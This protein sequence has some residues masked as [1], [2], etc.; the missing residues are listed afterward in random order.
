ME[1]IQIGVDVGGTFTDVVVQELNT[2]RMVLAKSFSTPDDPMRGIDDAIQRAL[3]E[4][5]GDQRD[6][7][8]VRHG[9]TIATNAA[10]ERRGAKTAL[11]T[12]KGF[13]DVLYVGRQTRPSL[14]NLRMRHPDPLVP[15]HLTF[16]V[17]ERLAWN[18]VIERAVDRSEVEAIAERLKVEGIETIAI[19][20]LHAY[21]N[22]ENERAAKAVLE[23]CLPGVPIS[24]SSEIC[25][26]L[27]E[28]ERTSTTAMNAFVTPPISAYVAAV[29]RDIEKFD[30][31]CRLHIMQSNGGAM[32]PR[33][34]SSKSAHTLL[35]GPAGG[36]IGAYWFSKAFDLPNI[37]TIDVGGTSADVGVISRGEVQSTREGKIAGLPIRIPLLDIHTVGAGG[38]SIA[39]I[40]PGGALKVGPKSAGSVPGPLCYGRGG[41]QA[42]VTDANVSLGYIGPEAVLGGHAR[43]DA[44]A[45][46]DGVEALARKLCLSGPEGAAGILEIANT[47]MMRAIRVLTVERGLD[48]KDF[49][50]LAFGGAGPLHAPALAKALSIDTIVV[51]PFAGVL[52]A[53]GMLAADVRHDFTRSQL[54]RTSDVTTEAITADFDSLT[55][56]ALDLMRVEGFDVGKVEMRPSVEMRYAGQAYEISIP[57]DIEDISRDPAVR[58][59]ELLAEAHRQRYGFAF[60][61]EP[62]ELVQIAVTASAQ[63]HDFNLPKLPRRKESAA[64]RFRKAWFDGADVSTEIIEHETLSPGRTVSGPAIIEARDATLIVPPGAVGHMNEFGVFTIRL[65]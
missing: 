16:E 3:A 5:R 4:L 55:A 10:L 30:D 28:F 18:G 17:D 60:N 13:R 26:Q 27:G 19:S 40:D 57:V 14:Y 38:G 53:V 6:V 47:V 25:P 62:A 9:T 29:Q 34:A 59:P 24:L 11:L 50:L 52:S 31:G 32:G 42:T 22:G 61:D 65:P 51:P 12:T 8:A 39:W 2:G 45:A 44:Q 63:I 37:I 48:P 49:V 7:I 36:L 1:K 21:E 35:S 41:T 20:F 15:R 46:K 56:E 64:K 23:E 54:V 33:I 43:I 58:L